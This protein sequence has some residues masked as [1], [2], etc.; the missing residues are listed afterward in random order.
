MC[1][2]TQWKVVDYQEEKS[3]FSQLSINPHNRDFP[4]GPVAETLPSKAEG[5]R[6]VP[7]WGAQIPQASWPKKQNIRQKQYSNKFNKDPHQ[8]KKKALKTINQS[9]QGFPTH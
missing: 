4:G 3:D 8:K 7:G 1:A 2:F 9:T 6:S 5:A